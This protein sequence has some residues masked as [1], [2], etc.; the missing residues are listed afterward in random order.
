MGKLKHILLIDD[1]EDEAYFFKMALGELGHPVQFTY[2]QEGDTT[3]LRLQENSI[4]A[5]D[6]LFLDW[7]MPRLTGSR[8]LE[9][10][11]KIPRY[12]TIPII[13]YTTSQAPE[14]K[15]LARKLGASY[16]LTKPSSIIELCKLL[17]DIF[18]REWSYSR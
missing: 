13:V 7:N 9:A 11:M 4:P 12:A 14:E 6:L 16:F 10:I 17:R 2:Y 3:L 1:D 8:F 5:P 18:A 15:D